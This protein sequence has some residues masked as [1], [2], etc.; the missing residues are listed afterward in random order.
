V[1]RIVLAALLAE[2]HHTIRAQ[3]YHA[4]LTLTGVAPVTKRSGSLLNAQFKAF[5]VFRSS[6]PGKSGAEKSSSE[7]SSYLEAIKIHPPTPTCGAP[8]PTAERILSPA[9]RCRRG[10]GVGAAARRPSTLKHQQL[11]WR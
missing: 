11:N 10:T 7:R 2:A 4:L 6:Q 1:G 9:K 3:D 8:G 5:I